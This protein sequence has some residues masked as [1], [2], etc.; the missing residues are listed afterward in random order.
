MWWTPGGALGVRRKQ[1]CE[2]VTISVPCS[3]TNTMPLLTN[4]CGG[5]VQVKSMDAVFPPAGLTVFPLR[6]LPRRRRRFPAGGGGSD[7]RQHHD[8]HQNCYCVAAMH[9]LGQQQKDDVMLCCDDLP[10]YTQDSPTAPLLAQAIA[11]LSCPPAHLCRLGGEFVASVTFH[12]AP[13]SL[14][15]LDT[16]PFLLVLTT[17]HRKW[18]LRSQA[19][20]DCSQRAAGAFPSNVLLFDCTAAHPD[21][22]PVLSSRN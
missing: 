9:R 22:L 15:M 6:S 14:Q 8:S 1:I 4:I 2:W 13:P 3:V 12:M 10:P 21:M 16:M 11:Q 17:H 18:W 19:R 5:S 7:H 20:S